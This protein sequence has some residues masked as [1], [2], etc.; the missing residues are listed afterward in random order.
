MF[1]INNLTI[2][3][4]NYLFGSFKYIYI[5]I[6]W[7]YKTW[8]C[9]FNR[10]ELIT[11]AHKHK[12][13]EANKILFKYFRHFQGM[14]C[15]I[16]VIFLLQKT[17]DIMKNVGFTTILTSIRRDTKS[18]F[19]QNIYFVLQKIRFEWQWWENIEQIL[20]LA[21]L[22]SLHFISCIFTYQSYIFFKFLISRH[23]Y[24]NHNS[25]MCYCIVVDYSS[26]ER[27]LS[28]L[29]FMSTRCIWGGRSANLVKDGPLTQNSC[30]DSVILSCN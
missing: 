29:L 4:I 28:A 27:R 2:K 24:I 12:P 9:Q 10:A 1:L 3:T 22:N 8:S 19:S 16:H 17:K 21:D 25:V 13:A 23:N 5:Y 15:N 7:K 11:L 6:F 18:D 14:N 30:S 26:E 20:C